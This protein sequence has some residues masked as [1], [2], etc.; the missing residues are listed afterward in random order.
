MS[1]IFARV[2]DLEGQG[3]LT[4]A[5]AE[6]TRLIDAGEGGSTALTRRGLLHNQ[7]GAFSRMTADLERAQAIG[8][9]DPYPWMWQGH[10]AKAMR[11]PH[12]AAACMAAALACSPPVYAPEM[13]V[14][15][16]DVCLMLGWLDDADRM[17]RALAPDVADWWAGTRR[18]ALER[19]RERHASTRT[20]LR[21]FRAGPP[22]RF[23]RLD[24]AARMLSLGRLRLARTLCEAL[25]REEPHDYEPI[26]WLSHVIARA[27]GAAEALAFLT[28][29]GEPHHGG[30]NWTRAVARLLHDLGRFA[31]V[32]E[33]VR[34]HAGGVTD[35]ELRILSGLAHIGLDRFAGLAEFCRGWMLGSLQS[36]PAAGLLVAAFT[37][38]TGEAAA[39]DPPPAS[40]R[41]LHL[42]Q[43]WNDPDVPADVSAT[44]ASWRTCNPELDATLFD[45]AG[46]AAFI[47]ARCGGEAAAAFARCR[48][49][50]MQADLFRIAFLA[51]AGGLYAD[52]D[53]LC[54]APMGPVLV[55]AAN[56]EVAAVRSGEIPNFLHNYFMG[57]RAGSPTLLRAV[58]MAASSILRA[59]QEGQEV[60]IWH[61]TGP[62]LVTRA[63]GLTL[64][65]RFDTATPDEF[66]LLPV[67][68]YR[69]LTRVAHE[70]DYKHRP[71]ANWRLS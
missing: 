14:Q 68:Q 11:R 5:L 55:R 24:L 52:A 8:P 2:Q 47:A 35:E 39:H 10:I 71:A 9:D 62:G 48:H 57:A 61:V 51:H 37:A 43:F 16:A 56:A 15:R 19:R 4:E 12:F 45:T 34:Q 31:D 50:A 67:Q 64:A 42:V 21:K 49:P 27:D 32:I 58:D 40:A 33:H 13:R 44:I 36:V 59:A 54:L 63:T 17:A 20:L 6:Y 66:V 60:D 22:T 23:M 65:E 7:L 3:R 70:L 1:D 29:L 30:L 25:I 38:G 69:A 53:E 26:E 18:D 46:A 28:A 41:R